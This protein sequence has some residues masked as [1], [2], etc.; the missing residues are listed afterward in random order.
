MI[1]RSLISIA[2]SGSSELKMEFPETDCFPDWRR[3]GLVEKALSDRLWGYS[4]WLHW[5]LLVW[6]LSEVAGQL[7]LLQFY[8]LRLSLPYSALRLMAQVVRLHILTQGDACRG[9]GDSTLQ[10]QRFG[11][12][13]LQQSLLHRSSSDY[14]T[15]TPPPRPPFVPILRRTN[16]L[17]SVLFCKADVRFWPVPHWTQCTW[18]EG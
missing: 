1:N 8:W 2:Q 11:F 7:T 13:E 9:L 4:V 15:N 10:G 17:Y 5:G 14:G 6:E 3:H 12:H 18:E 16:S